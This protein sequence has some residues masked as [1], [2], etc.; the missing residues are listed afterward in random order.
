MPKLE[1]I[2]SCLEKIHTI[3][4]NE[5]SE[6]VCSEQKQGLI[7]YYYLRYK[8]YGEASD[9]RQINQLLSEVIDEILTGFT[10]LTSLHGFLIVND[11]LHDKLLNAE[12]TG[13]IYQLDTFLASQI[14]LSGEAISLNPFQGVIGIVH[15][16]VERLPNPEVEKC[17]WRHIPLVLER[18]AHQYPHQATKGAEVG[19]G[20][21]N[22]ITG[23]L[24]VLLKLCEKG[25]YV[26]DIK[27]II[28]CRLAHMISCRQE[29]DFFAERF[30][31]FP[32]VI[33]AN[34]GECVFG[35]RM[36]WSDGDL[37]KSLFL[38]KACNIFQ[39]AKFEQVANL[40]GL[41][42]LLRKTKKT[43][44]V[45]RACF[46][47]GAAGVA[48]TYRS[49]YTMSQQPAY[50]EG[51][52]YW[53]KRTVKLLKQEIEAEYYQAKALDLF[54][55]LIGSALVLLDYLLQTPS[56]WSKTLLL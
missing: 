29:I 19:L 24:F 10:E 12:V 28:Y 13:K 33:Q 51:Y 56:A 50:Q 45:R 52:A 1:D 17:L 7:V 25:L 11:L 16:F 30:S 15:Y 6:D 31:L 4:Q 8:L 3:V 49:L 48:Q 2:N 18:F 47:A 55:G 26:N 53:I 46:Y 39:D 27:A 35:R 21:I 40:V 37:N 23:V 20:M 22:G 42:T 32:E 34:T 5:R 43:T 54:R 36:T 44:A 14:A 38:Y 41:N 9:A